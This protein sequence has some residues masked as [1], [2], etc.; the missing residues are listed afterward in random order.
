[1][2]AIGAQHNPPAYRTSLQELAA[3][4]AALSAKQAELELQQARRQELVGEVRQLLRE[5]QE[6]NHQF[7]LVLSDVYMPGWLAGSRQQQ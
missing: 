6:Q 7:D 3:A 5:R 1:M 2:S 4:R